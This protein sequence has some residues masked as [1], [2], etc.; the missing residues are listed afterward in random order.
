MGRGR[1]FADTEIAVIRTLAEERYSPSE[2]AQR[3]KRS[4]KEIN[5]VLSRSSTAACRRRIATPRKISVTT[6]RAGLRTVR[7]GV[8]SASELVLEFKLDI[9]KHRMQQLMRKAKH[10]GYKG[11]KRASSL[12][13][14]HKQRQLKFA[15]E[16]LALNTR[17]GARTCLV[18]RRSS[19]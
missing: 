18:M 15:R 5:N 4:R 13:G 3:T 16:H 7:R 19:T 6:L 10:L 2:I 9:G 8:Q 11:M 1:M 17:Y 12:S 14:E